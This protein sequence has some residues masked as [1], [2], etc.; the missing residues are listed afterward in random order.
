M[1]PGAKAGVKVPRLILNAE[2]LAFAD[3]ALVTVIVYVLVVVPSCAVTTVV[4]VLVP[5]F[6]AIGPEAVPGVTVVPFTFTVDV[7]TA[8]KGVMVMVAAP[9]TTSSVY[10]V[11]EAEKVG[12]KAPALGLRFDR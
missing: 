3:A 4:T 11:L 12:D 10:A 9:F 1:V 8:V 5:T 7:G 6:N 2:R